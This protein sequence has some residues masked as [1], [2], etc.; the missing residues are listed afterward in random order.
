MSDSLDIV[1]VMEETTEACSLEID[2]TLSPDFFTSESWEENIQDDKQTDL[3]PARVFLLRPIIERGKVLPQGNPLSNYPVILFFHEQSKA[4]ALQAD[5]EPVYK[6]MRILV[7]QFLVRLQNDPR[8]RKIISYTALEEAYRTDRC[9]AGITLNLVVEIADN[10]PV[11]L[12]RYLMNE[13][14]TQYILNETG[15][16]IIVT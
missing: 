2:N 7:R 3:H 11:C 5:L 8:I 16:K 13:D 10:N 14:K 6:R 9:N 15:H 12:V 4:D 1:D